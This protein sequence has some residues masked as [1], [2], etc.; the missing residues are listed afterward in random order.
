MPWPKLDFSQTS[1]CRGVS[2]S[3]RSVAMLVVIPCVPPLR[4]LGA[5]RPFPFAPPLPR[6]FSQGMRNAAA[7]VPVGLG[8]GEVGGSVY[9]ELL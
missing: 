9:P 2:S 5:P 8:N 4:E 6:L 7:R 1:K 3:P